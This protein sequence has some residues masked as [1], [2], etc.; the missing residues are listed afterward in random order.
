MDFASDNT[1]G[2]H[3]SV[4]AALAQANE[5]RAASYGADALTQHVEAQFAEAFGHACAV[6]P[7]VTG[8]AANS[9]AL[10]TACPPYGAVLAHR[11][12]HVHTDECGAPEFFTAG[13]KT[14]L[15]DG[16]DGRIDPESLHG[17]LEQHPAGRVHSVQPAILTLTQAT[18]AGTVYRPEAVAALAGI[19]HARRVAVHIDGARLANAAAFLSCGLADLTWRAGVDLVSFGATKNGALAAEALVVFDPGWF[20]GIAFRRKRAGHLLSKLRFISAQLSALIARDLWR[21]LA[22]HANAMARD[23]GAAFADHGVALA[24]P[25]EANMCFAWLKPEDAAA[26]QRA[27]A[28]FYAWPW[29]DAPRADHALYRFVTAWSTTAADIA[30]FRALLGRTLG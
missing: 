14:L 7:V 8:S 21:E 25:V 26:L 12:A 23:L 5:G 9:L 17:A 15:L 24:H 2:A 28:L 4:I 22:A 27:G 10:A 13:A 30:D 29:A 20:D 1:A 18:E 6:F 16:R 3:P 19:A 11:H